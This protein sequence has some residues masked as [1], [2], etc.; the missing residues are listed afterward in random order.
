MFAALQQRRITSGPILLAVLAAC[1][2]ATGCG[3][4]PGTEKIIVQGA[5][6]RLGSLVAEALLEMRVPAENLIPVSRTP[7][8]LSQFARLGA[9]TRYGDFTEPDSLAQ[10]YAGGTH[11]LLISM[12]GGRGRR[13]QLHAGAIDAAVAAGVKH[14]AYTSHVNADKFA[15]S[16]IAPDHR[17]TEQHLRDS[18]VA[19]TMLRNS[20]YMNGL[21]E[22]AAAVSGAE[23]HYRAMSEAEHI[24]ALI[25]AGRTEAAARGQLG[26]R[27]ELNSP[28]LRVVSTAVEDLTGRPPTSLRTLLGANRQR[29]QAAA[30]GQ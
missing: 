28:Y 2:I 26:F 4:S 29:L 15:S 27:A 10:A 22:E 14:S 1:A 3:R 6:G 7:E 12:G 20:I 5:S 23:T 13:A 21:V 11:M 9:A 19:W 30:N 24:A 17:A 8:K 18:G 25:A 16:V